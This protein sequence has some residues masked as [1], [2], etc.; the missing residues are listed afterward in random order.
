MLHKFLD[1]CTNAFLETVWSSASPYYLSHEKDNSIEE[2]QKNL[3]D[4][5]NELAELKKQVK[6]RKQTKPV[7]LLQPYARY[8]FKIHAPIDTKHLPIRKNIALVSSELWKRYEK[9]FLQLKKKGVVQKYRNIFLDFSRLYR[10]QGMNSIGFCPFIRYFLYSFEREMR[11]LPHCGKIATPYWAH[12]ESLKTFELNKKKKGS[13]PQLP[14]FNNI[15]AILQK[16]QFESLEEVGFSDALQDLGY[17]IDNW[18]GNNDD[19]LKNPMTTP[20]FLCKLAFLDLLWTLWQLKCSNSRDYHKRHGKGENLDDSI[21]GALTEG[22]KQPTNKTIRDSYY[23]AYDVERD[24]T[25][26]EFFNKDTVQ[27]ISK[28]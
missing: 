5:R 20:L 26:M 19:S 18:H 6:T 11:K 8:H 9:G 1:I 25:F 14:T 15:R 4:T 22:V 17:Y 7:K 13:T 27:V 23:V 10:A 24:G 16:D 3:E 2:L 12:C 21:F 28:K